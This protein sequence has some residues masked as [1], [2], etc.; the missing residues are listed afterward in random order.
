MK[1]LMLPLTGINRHDNSP[2]LLAYYEAMWDFEEYCDTHFEDGHT[3][4]GDTCIDAVWR[5]DMC[6]TIGVPFDFEENQ[7]KREQLEL[8]TA[9]YREA[10]KILEASHDLSMLFNVADTIR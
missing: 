5:E 2:T 8:W 1:Q 7:V 10:I 9:R 4:G 3:E 6:V